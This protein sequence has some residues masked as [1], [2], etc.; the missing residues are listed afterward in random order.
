[1]SPSVSA[2]PSSSPTFVGTQSAFFTIHLELIEKLT[3]EEQLAFVTG[4]E[5]FVEQLKIDG[6]L[7]FPQVVLEFQSL[8]TR[9]FNMTFTTDG[10]STSMT[11]TSTYISN[12]TPPSDRILQQQV[13]AAET[14]TLLELHF[15]VTTIYTGSDTQFDLFATL[16]PLFQKPDDLWIHMLGNYNDVFLPLR[17][18]DVNAIQG[19]PNSSQRSIT[20]GGLSAILLVALVAVGLAIAAAVYSV[21]IHTLSEYGEALESPRGSACDTVSNEIGL[22]QTKDNFMDTTAFVETRTYPVQ[23]SPEV[24]V[25]PENTVIEE[26]KETEEE[27]GRPSIM[28]EH[29]FTDL[30]GLSQRVGESTL[31]GG[32]LDGV[33]LQR[34]HGSVDPPTESEVGVS[35]ANY[36]QYGYRIEATSSRDRQA[37]LIRQVLGS[38]PVMMN[39]NVVSEDPDQQNTHHPANRG[40]YYNGQPNMSY[41]VDDQELMLTKSMGGTLGA[42]PIAGASP[43]PTPS[44]THS[45]NDSFFNNILSG[46]RKKKQKQAIMHY[47]ESTGYLG[48][49]PLRH[50][51][52]ADLEETVPYETMVRRGGLYDVFAP[53]GPI[54]IVVDTTKDGPCVHSLKPTSPMLGL[55]NPG[56]LIVGLDDEDTR[57]MTAATLT[58]LM[59]RKSNQKERKITLLAAAGY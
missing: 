47:G 26:K 24:H 37:N 42:A 36:E 43:S 33:P 7:S 50:D 51:S 25:F 41:Y 32:R 58:R 56:D 17:P 22:F 10:T 28:S 59:A 20:A 13:S 35:E 57:G 21:R 29:V 39:A 38:R 45:A 27:R 53:A 16:N 14:T 40:L 34:S 11:A 4:T 8:V 1:M 12:G 44:S 6:G 46:K 18:A 54:G 30:E 23:K 2:M 52:Q 49:R 19:N 3:T 5:D 55:I 9:G 31:S 48:A 15:E